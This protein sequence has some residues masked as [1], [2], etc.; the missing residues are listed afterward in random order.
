[1][2]YSTLPAAL[3][4]L[5]GLDRKI[6]LINRSGEESSISFAELRRRALSLLHRFQSRGIAAGD[7]MML[8][9][10]RNDAFL[11]AY[12]AWLPALR[13]SKSGRCSG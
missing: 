10:N 1:M 4:E 5:S 13:T 3:E 7:E 8:V 12:W 2:R 9:V 11:D 6:R